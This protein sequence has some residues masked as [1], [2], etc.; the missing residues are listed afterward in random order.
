MVHDAFCVQ[1]NKSKVRH[2][3][4]H[5]LYRRRETVKIFCDKK[6]TQEE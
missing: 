2:I 5:L 4:C 6:Y 3:F 1:K